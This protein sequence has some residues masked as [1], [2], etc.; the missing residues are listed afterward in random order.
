M[1]RPDW[2]VVPA[3]KAQDMDRIQELLNKGR[4]HTVC[5]SAQCPNI[6]ECFAHKTC[7]F[8]ILGDVCTRNC[9]FCAVQHGRPQAPDPDEPRFVAESAKQLGLQYVVVTSVTR[10]DLPDGGA[11]QFASTIRAVKTAIPSAEVEVLI[12]DFQGDPDPLRTVMRAGPSIINHNIETV[13]RLYPE[14][15]PQ[16]VYERSLELLRN[17]AASAERKGIVTKSGLML[18]L[19]EPHEEVVLAMKDLLAAGCGILTLGQYLRPSPRHLPIKEYVHPD[20]FD[21]LRRIGRDLGFQKV[22]AGPLVRSSY[23]AAQSFSELANAP[24]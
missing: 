21:R 3:P 20:E 15:R 10:D 6:G 12:P 16:A 22:V 18:G 11:G 14:V 1:K 19:G 7:T 4:L 13:P 17:V 8:M 24:G 2:L 5:E 9:S 23:H